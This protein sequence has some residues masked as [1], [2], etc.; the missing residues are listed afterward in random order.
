MTKLSASTIK[1]KINGA[2]NST[3]DATA[4]K[5]KAARKEV[6]AMRA[7]R[8]AEAQRAQA[9]IDKLEALKAAQP[10]PRQHARDNLAAAYDDFMG[11]IETPSWK[12]AICGALLGLALSCA[13]GWIIGQVVGLIIAA[14]LTITA[15]SFIAMMIFVIGIFISALVGMTVGSIGYAYVASAKIDEHASAVKNKVTGWFKRDKFNGVFTV[16]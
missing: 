9:A 3:V 11:T 2:V 1:S 13:T 12:R 7:E 4:A 8:D 6:N 14:V 5:L 15:S 16:A 10:D